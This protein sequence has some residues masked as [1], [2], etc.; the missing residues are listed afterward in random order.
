DAQILSLVA[1]GST[2][3][4]TAV[5]TPADATNKNMLWASSDE[6]IVTVDANGVVTPVD[7]GTAVITVTTEDGEY[8]ATATVTV[9]AAQ[10]VSPPEQEPELPRTGGLPL[11]LMAGLLIYMGAYMA[12][13]EH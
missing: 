11:E 9:D 1:G 7:A 8:T 3:K 13:K 12:K 2:D 10:V 6:T 4:L 5:I